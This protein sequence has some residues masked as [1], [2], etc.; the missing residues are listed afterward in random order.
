M[1]KKKKRK[2]IFCQLLFGFCLTL[3]DDF[4]VLV[5]R[6]HLVHDAPHDAGLSDV[7]RVGVVGDELCSCI[8]HIPRHGIAENARHHFCS[9]IHI[10]TLHIRTLSFSTHR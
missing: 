10:L 3:V 1:R 8:N 6:F 4:L 2:Q 7:R 5:H 9:I